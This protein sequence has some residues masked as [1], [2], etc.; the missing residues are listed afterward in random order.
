MSVIGQ[1]D[2]HLSEHRI[3]L[4]REGR[5]LITTPQRDPDCRWC[6]DGGDSRY[7]RAD[8]SLL[9]LRPTTAAS[10]KSSIARRLIAALTRR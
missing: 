8:T 7:A 6:G 3:T 10:A 9:P 1:A 5:T 2:E 4:M